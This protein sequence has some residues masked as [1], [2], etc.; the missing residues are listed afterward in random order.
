MKKAKNRVWL[1]E[2]SMSRWLPNS[3]PR[4]LVYND[5]GTIYEW[6]EW[7]SDA[8]DWVKRKGLLLENECP[9]CGD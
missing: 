1:F 7:D 4:Y 9:T 2:S 6:F 5:E 3:E 8:R